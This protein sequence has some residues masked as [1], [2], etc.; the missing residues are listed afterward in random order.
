MPEID[1]KVN[2]IRDTIRKA[3][4]DKAINSLAKVV[5][6]SPNGTDGIFKAYDFVK[7]RV[8]FE[9]E[10]FG[11]DNYQYP[12]FTLKTGAGDC[13]DVTMLLASLLRAQGY[14]VGIKLAPRGKDRYHI[15]LVVNTSEGWLPLDT[16]IP[17]PAGS[18]IRAEWTKVYP[19]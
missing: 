16:T 11:Q 12:T 13:E 5:I 3:V 14:Q 8:R 9:E 6:G 10:P 4:F 1:E 19:V 17:E 7:S 18:E 2:L 15:W